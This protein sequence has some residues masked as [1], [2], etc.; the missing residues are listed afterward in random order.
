MCANHRGI[1]M[2]A[3]NLSWSAASGWTSVQED[4]AQA[5]LVIL[6]DSRS[7]LETSAVYNDLRAFF[8]SAH[9]IGCSTGGQISNGDVTDEVPVALAMQFEKAEL[10]MASESISDNSR[11]A[12]VGR[13]LGESLAGEYLRAVF[14]ISDGLNVNGSKL[15]SGLREAVGDKV[16][17]TGG[18]AG[19]GTTFARTV[20]IADADPA[21][22]KVAAIG[23]Y[24]HSLVVGHGSAGGW[25]KFGPKRVIT[26]SSDNL[27]IELDGK[28]ALELYKSYLGEEAER[29]P[30]SALLYPLMVMDPATPGH[31]IVR[32]V[33]G[34]DGDKSTMTFAGDVPEGWHAQ[35]MRGYF[36]NLAVGAADAAKSASV[37]RAGDHSD[38]AAVLI[39][40]IGRRLLMGQCVADEIEAAG[41]VLGPDVKSIGFYSYGEISPNA[42][43]GFCELHNQTM[44]ITTF[45]EVR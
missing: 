41:N 16:V 9:I 4:V 22:N 10:R 25:D 29:L 36:E 34:V 14:V 43:T 39:S 5:Q 2:K 26:R 1:R 37:D 45:S 27:L 30:G 19:D 13:K 17:V 11:S 35:L 38:V 23:F 21:A 8:P 3:Q 24:G 12:S 44:T 40:C 32:T 7:S 33:L 15:I 31:G 6:F 42:G 28:P 20:V 18:L